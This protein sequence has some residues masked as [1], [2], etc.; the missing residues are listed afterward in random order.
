[1][2]AIVKSLAG[3]G[4]TLQEVAEPHTT[5]FGHVL[6]KVQSVAICGTD[7]H[8]YSWDAWAAGRVK[9]P[10]IMGH[11]FSGTIVEVGEGVTSLKVGDFVSGESHKICGHCLQ[12]RTGQG[13]VCRNTQIFGVDTDGCFREYFAVPEASILKNDPRIPPHIACLQDPLGNAVHAAMQGEV[14]G[15]SVAVLGCGPIGLFGVA[16]CRALGAG[17]IFASDTS[18]YRLELAAK[19]GADQLFQI[20]GDDIEQ[21]I[22]DA[23]DGQGVDVVLEM[24]GAV[25]AIQQAMRLARPGGRVSLMGIPSR[26]VELRVSED[27]IFKGLTLHG[28]V[29]RRLY[30]TWITMQSLLANNRITI[31]P[32]LTHHLPFAEFEHGM[33]LMRSGQCGKVVLDLG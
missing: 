6:V 16:V 7:F 4:A 9:P 20:P 12:C 26:S 25:P 21:A 32:I 10:V 17:Q 29:G 31:E 1:M 24:S 14:A 27:I 8:V 33:A 19:V 15:R 22:L 30:D 5:P 2:K 3:E 13:H 11:E 18:R 28:V 23:T